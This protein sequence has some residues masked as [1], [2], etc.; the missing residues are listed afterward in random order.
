[1][2]GIRGINTPRRI[3]RAKF[4]IWVQYQRSL[5]H[6]GQGDVGYMVQ[7]ASNGKNSMIILLLIPG[8]K[9]EEEP[10]SHSSTEGH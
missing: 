7:I 5:P 3:Q 1:M 6:F 10:A 9:V 2:N 4:S 8:R